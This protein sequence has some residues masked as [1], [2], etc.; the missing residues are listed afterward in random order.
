MKKTGI[1]VAIVAVVCVLLWGVS[2][3]NKLVS[4]EETVLKAWSQVENVYQRRSDLIPNLVNTVKGAADFEKS[5]LT[6]VIKM[7]SNA[8]NVKLDV[9]NLTSSGIDAYQKAQDQLSDAI[10]KT[11]SLTVERYPE[12]A[13]TQAFRDFQVQLE[14]TE[15]RI[16]VER[17]KFNDVVLA[18]NT[19][20]RK[21]PNNLIAGLLGF[22][23]KAF[24]SATPDAQSTVEVDF[25][26]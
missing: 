24:F 5:T 10:G 19:L 12:L 9:D 2:V 16:S 18:Y 23:K 6:E 25:A 21:F 4:A 7:R 15:N 17:G 14:G 1:I 26:L 20:L 8:N 11:I 22:E 13:A 3:N